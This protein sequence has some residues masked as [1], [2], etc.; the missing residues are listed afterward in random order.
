M[1]QEIDLAGLL[2]NPL[3]SLNLIRY[4]GLILKT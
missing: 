4:Y 3:L 2:L 1:I